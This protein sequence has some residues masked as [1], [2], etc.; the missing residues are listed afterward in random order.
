MK[1][2]EKQPAL[3]N[4]FSTRF[5]RPGAMPYLFVD[6]EDA[7]AIIARFA[8]AQWRAQIVGPHGSG[9][10]TLLRALS[11]ALERADSRPHVIE[12]RD[13]QRRLPRGWRRE[14]KRN[15]ARLIIVD[16]YEQLC[17]L[18]RA[19]LAA[20]CRARRW[21]M[22]VA[23][24]ADVGFPTIYR[25]QS[26]PRVAEAV[27]ARLLAQSEFE[28]GRSMI[29]EQLSAAGGNVREMLLT[30]YDVYERQARRV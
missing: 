3:S 18:E 5:I 7:D 8:R 29:A 30:L 21:G 2:S 25:T 15:S 26:T 11:S 9:K 22:L 12:L 6:G 23:A 1:T 28:A 14:A 4:P 13:G 19:L 20:H 24:H 16:G 27:V 10:S 17:M